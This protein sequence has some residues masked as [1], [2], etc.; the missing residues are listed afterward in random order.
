MAV[1]KKDRIQL[2]PLGG[3]RQV[4]VVPDIPQPFDRRLGMPPGPSMMAAPEDKQ[5]QVHHACGH[6]VLCPPLCTT[7]GACTDE[8]TGLAR[9]RLVATQLECGMCGNDTERC[10]VSYRRVI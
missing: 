7:R 1:G 8:E 10:L 6:G 5:V 9:P 2:A 4:L 3:L